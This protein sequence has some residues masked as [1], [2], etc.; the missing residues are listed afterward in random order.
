MQVYENLL[1]DEEAMHIPFALSFIVTI[2]TI[3]GQMEQFLIDLK[4]KVCREIPDIHYAFVEHI[5]NIMSPKFERDM[6]S[7]G[8]MT[9]REYIEKKYGEFLDMTFPEIYRYIYDHALKMTE[10]VKVVRREIKK[11]DPV[12]FKDYVLKRIHEGNWN[13]VKENY[14]EWKD[15]YSE[16]TLDMLLER[17]ER[18]LEKY[19]KKGIMCFEDEPSVQKMNSVDYDYHR[20]HLNSDF[21]HSTEYHKAYTNMVLKYA[22][23]KDGMLIVDLKKYGKYISNY[24]YQFTESQKVALIE[25]LV[26]L[27]L[28]HQDMQIF[29]QGQSLGSA[30]SLVEERCVIEDHIPDVLAT[31]E[32]MR[33]WKKVQEAG[34]VDEHF[35]PKLSRT[36]AA[37]LA[38]AMAERLGIKE[39]WKVFENL[40]NR[41]NMHKDIY[42]AY[43]QQQSL[44][45]Q[46]ELKR[47]FG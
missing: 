47:I 23:R 28:I 19:L 33:L 17:Q 25:V 9:L 3:V 34:Y 8:N 40:W 30:A 5:H 6:A 39:K 46:E 26:S 44:A 13:D 43:G 14:Q 12:L 7:Y 45:F 2:V 42:E 15:K 21:V 10:L 32:A 35:Q 27:D 11:A 38:D 22:T 16:V 4:N 37:L 20:G 36:Q 31:P 18:E 29:T 1:E 24:F 41:R